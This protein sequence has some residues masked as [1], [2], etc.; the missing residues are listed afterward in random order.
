VT[1]TAEAMRAMARRIRDLQTEAAAHKTAIEQLVTQWRPDLLE[2]TG[3]G[4]VI[5]AT[6]LTV[7]SHPGRIRTEAAFAAIAGVAP[8][9]ASSGK[10]TRHRLNRRG[11]RNLNSAIHIIAIQRQRHD[12]RTQAYF[13]RRRAEG[14]TDREIRRCLKRYIARELYNTLEKGLDT[15]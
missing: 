11:D 5:G 8:I 15:Q 14:K 10:T 9:P 3:V 6:V 13:D 2:L 1:V 7:W 4:P 12:A